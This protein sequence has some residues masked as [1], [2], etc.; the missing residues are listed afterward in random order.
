[1]AYEGYS[2]LLIDKKGPIAYVTVNRPEVHN[3][4]D[5]PSW[6]EV[7]HLFQEINADDEIGVVIITGAGDKSFVSGADVGMLKRTTAMDVLNSIATA[8]LNEVEQSPKAVIAAV[9][10]YALG[11]GCE[12]ALSADMRV[13]VKRA[14]LGQL[15]VNLG[16]IPGAG[17]TQR[18]QRLVGISKAKELILTG[19]AISADEAKELGLVNHV[20]DS[21]EDLMPFC[22][23]L[24][25]KITSKSPVSINLAKT[26]IM[27]GSNTDLQSGLMFERYAFALACSTED[28]L[29]GTSAFLEKRKPEFRGR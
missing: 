18:L 2:R 23:A 8:A 13:A 27:V 7:Y 4:M 25:A 1:M 20:V 28:K 5:E 24:A 14:K 10:G 19:D 3:A 9:N 26:A 15:E 6:N 21:Y 29:E 22:E 17:G 11:G 16:I 12:L